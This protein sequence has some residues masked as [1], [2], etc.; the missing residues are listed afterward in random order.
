MLIQ[1]SYKKK[2]VYANSLRWTN[3]TSLLLSKQVFDELILVL[4]HANNQLRCSKG[5]SAANEYTTWFHLQ[6]FN[7][8][9]I[10][11][12]NTGLNNN[13]K[14]SVCAVGNQEERK[15]VL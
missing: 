11:L 12:K 4:T 3:M 14:N 2:N 6:K 7:T 8:A 15:D 5:L 10:S 13:F 9:P 1:V